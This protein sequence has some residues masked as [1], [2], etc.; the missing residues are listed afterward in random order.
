[1]MTTDNTPS[2]NLD[3]LAVLRSDYIHLKAGTWYEKTI[4]PPGVLRLLLLYF[5]CREFKVA[6]R[7]RFAHMC[8]HRNLRVLA[9]WVYLRTKICLG[10][11][12]H[13]AAVI[14]P[15][16]MIQHGTDIVIGREVCIGRDAV[17][18]NGVTLGGRMQGGDQFAQPR[19]G[20]GV[21]IGTGAKVLGGL[22]LGDDVRIGANAVVL[23]A[24]GENGKVYVGVPAREIDPR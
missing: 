1:M 19:I 16:L 5:T 8:H 13:P 3:L 18:M 23:A 20:N 15:G 9:K 6:A 4:A 2:P 10:V 24:S 12:I 7:Y 11:D 17:L 22:R 21:V 14:G